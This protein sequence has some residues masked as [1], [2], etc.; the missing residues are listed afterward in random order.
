MKVY[1]NLFDTEPLN[2]ESNVT[3]GMFDGIHLGHKKVLNE[4][5]H[6]EGKKNIVISFSNHPSA[7]FNP[8]RKYKLLFDVNEKLEFFQEIGIDIVYL[9][10]FNEKIA[11]YP[12]YNFVDEILIKKLNCKNLI[13]GYDNRFGKSREGTIDFVQQNFSNQINAIKVEP[14]VLDN[15]IVSSSIIKEFISKGLIQKGNKFLGFNYFVNG[16][17]ISG[18]KLGSQIGFPTA[19]LGIDEY[20]LIPSFGVYLVRVH[21][22]DNLFFGVTNIGVRPTVNSNPDNVNIETHVFEF[23]EDIYQ[24]II[25]VEF[26]SKL[27]DEKKFGS[28]DELKNQISMD[29][30]TGKELIRNI[31]IRS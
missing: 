14:Y 29:I 19:N 6:F 7:Y 20:K 5:M 1:Y 27:R 16:R 28:L 17:V 4:L 23:N 2:E 18:K 25:R 31:H 26:L 10:E 3:I 9:I 15:E 8:E 30:Q 21:I 11:Q 13:L 22:D 24:K 12:A